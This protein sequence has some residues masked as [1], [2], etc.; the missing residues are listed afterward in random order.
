M[1]AHSERGS[2]ACRRRQIYSIS[3]WGSSRVLGTSMKD[4]RSLMP[5]GG[6]DLSWATFGIGV[7]CVSCVA[8]GGGGGGG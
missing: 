2:E 8:C 6:E 7:G 3:L 1:T 5:G 4:E